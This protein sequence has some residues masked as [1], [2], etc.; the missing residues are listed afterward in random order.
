LEPYKRFTKFSENDTIIIRK[1]F[2]K[3]RVVVS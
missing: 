2:F 3:R 1:R